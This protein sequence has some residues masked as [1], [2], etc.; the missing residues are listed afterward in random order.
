MMAIVGPAGQHETGELQQVLQ[1]VI[2]PVPASVRQLAGREKA[3]ALGRYARRALDRSAAYSGVALGALEKG[4][5]G[6]PRPTGGVYWSLS[7]CPE[8]VAAV[9]APYRIGID[10]EKITTFAADLRVRVASQDE[11]E[12]A[13]RVDDVLCCRYWTAK[14]AVLKAVG[15]GLGGLDRCA[16]TELVDE[17]HLR[18]SYDSEPWTV[19]HCFEAPQHVAAITAAARNVRWHSLEG[20]P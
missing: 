11:W 5:R 10:I 6:N 14:E 20:D 8:Y 19:S 17:S 7:H 18:L 4:P 2:M 3:L 1:P 16:I 9:T 15:A 12:L 13:P